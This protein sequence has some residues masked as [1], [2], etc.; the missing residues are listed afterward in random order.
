VLGFI[1]YRQVPGQD[2][3]TTDVLFKVMQLFAFE[4]LIPPDGTP[5][6]LDV[7]R[8]LAPLAVVY[9]AV[10]TAISLLR[11]QATRLRVAWYRNH[12]VVIG[13]GATGQVVATSLARPARRRDSWRV[14]ALEV[15]ETNKNV[16]SARAQGVRVLFGDGAI[17]TLLKRTRVAYARHVIVLA[18]DDSRNLQIAAAAR[19]LLKEHG[20]RATLH[21]CIVATDLWQELSQLQLTTARPKVLTEYVNLADRTALRLLDEVRRAGLADA[22][23][24]LVDGDTPVAVRVVTHLVRLSTQRGQRPCVHLT[25]PLGRDLAPRLRLLEPWCFEVADIVAHEHGTLPSSGHAITLAIACPTEDDAEAITRGLLLARRLQGPQIIS[26]VYRDA[27]EQVLT[28]AGL[29]SLP[30]KL[31][32]AKADALGRELMERSGI[33][34]MARARHEQYVAGEVR[35]GVMPSQNPSLVPWDDLAENLKE[36]NRRFAEGVGRVLSDIGAAVEPLMG[37]APYDLPISGELLERLA[38]EEHSRWVK[39]LQED[40]WKP[41]AG[42]K[43]AEKKEHPL[44]VP[45]EELSDAERA[46]DRDAF[47]ALPEMLARI[48]YTITLPKT[49]VL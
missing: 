44:L 41:T 20:G 1:G 26:A 15:D 9:A 28:S 5:W 32:S 2:L 45:W 10:V 29:G 12:I 16:R 18:G 21:L 22:T 36:Q 46:K 48:G 14:V 7:A 19:R 34:V 40:G 33:E 43:H 38:R 42:P 27:S 35:R 39:S 3:S 25:S 24:V 8:F 30:L 23:E 49:S 13:L 17:D 4:A 37:P 11:D 31:V 6:Q 47:T